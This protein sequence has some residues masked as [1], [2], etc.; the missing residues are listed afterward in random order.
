LNGAFDKSEAVHPGVSYN[1]APEDRLRQ[2]DIASEFYVQESKA[3][4]KLEQ[5]M[6]EAKEAVFLQNE[7]R[8]SQLFL[9]LQTQVIV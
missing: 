9:C 4:V 8:F 7:V 1:P 5:K 2:I 6:T 3:S